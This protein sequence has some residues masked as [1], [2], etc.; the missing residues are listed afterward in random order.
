M[1]LSEPVR[2]AIDE[3]GFTQPTAVQ[4]AA[5]EPASAGHDLIVQSRT[6]TGKTLAFGLPL[7]DRLVEEDAGLSALILAPTREL[8]GQIVDE[9]RDVADARGLAIAAVYGG[10]G[11]ER[12]RRAAAAA[13]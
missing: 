2:R 6:G 1:G 8:A 13:H 11:I 7:V 3:L 12:Q 9:L 4:R 5:F 10:T